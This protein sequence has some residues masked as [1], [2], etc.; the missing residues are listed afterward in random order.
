MIALFY[1][2]FLINIVLAFFMVFIEHKRLHRVA[3]WL[4][5][6]SI[7]PIIGFI[8][9]VLLGVG[10]FNRNKKFLATNV[11]NGIN[12]TTGDYILIHDS[13]RVLLS[14]KVVDNIIEMKDKYDAIL[15]Y[16]KVKDTIKENKNNKLVTLNRESLIAAS[17]PQCGK[18]DLLLDAYNKAKADKISFTD[19]ISVIERYYPNVEIGLVEANEENFKVTTPLDYKILKE[20]IK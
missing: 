7:L 10:V 14:S 8:L 18:R 6:F 19:D 2:I 9:Y 20:L 16:S 15:T 17:T 1:F 12:K 5:V 13:A 4:F 3:I 11:F